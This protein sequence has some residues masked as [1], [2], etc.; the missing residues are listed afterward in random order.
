M[1]LDKHF[2]D[3]LIE[4]VGR[5]NWDTLPDQTKMIILNRWKDE[6]KT[7]Y[8][9]PDTSEDYLDAGGFIPLPGIPDIPGKG[10]SGGMFYMEKYISVLPAKVPFTNPS[11]A[12]RLKRYSATAQ[13]KSRT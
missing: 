5:N 4:L 1:I 9:G 10:V 6:V 7:H 13:R 3:F 11:T 12:R 2:K 8:E